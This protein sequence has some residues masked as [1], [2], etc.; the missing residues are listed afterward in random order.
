MRQGAVAAADEQQVS[1][2]EL[3]AKLCTVA[4][5]S[6]DAAR[7]LKRLVVLMS[8][9]V[10]GSARQFFREQ[11]KQG[12]LEEADLEQVGMVALL[13]AASRYRVN[14]G[15]TFEQWSVFPVRRAMADLVRMQSRDVHVSDHVG[16]GRRRVEGDRISGFVEL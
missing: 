16:R 5:E 8:P 7:I 4:A 10:K 15:T 3:A 1:A 6:P 14:G 9:L 11:G 13:K 2:S 12:T